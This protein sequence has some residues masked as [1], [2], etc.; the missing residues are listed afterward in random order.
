MPRR[1][2]S[3]LNITPDTVITTDAGEDFAIVSGG[4]VFAGGYGRI[5]QA[6]RIGEGRK[7]YAVKFMLDRDPKSLPRKNRN[8]VMAAD[9]LRFENEISHLKL[10]NGAG[11]AE[12]QDNGDFTFPFPRYYG[13]GIKLHKAFYVME[14]LEPI[15]YREIDTDAERVDFVCDLCDAVRLLHARGLVHYD[16]KPSNIMRRPHAESP[17]QWEYVLSDFGSVHK[18]EKSVRVQGEVSV[19]MLPNGERFVVP[20]TPGYADPLEDLHT[21][22]GD[23]YAVGQVIRD[24]FASDVPPHWAPI[25]FRSISRNRD[26]RYSEIS[27]MREDVKKMVHNAAVYLANAFAD[28]TG[29]EGIA[30]SSEKRRVYVRHGARI[31]GD[32][33]RRSPFKTIGEA[34]VAAES[35]DIIDVGAGVY[36]ESIDLAG[37]RLS[38]IASAGPRKTKIVGEPKRSVV[39][40]SAGAG[41]TLIKGFSISGGVGTPVPSSHGQDFY[42]GGVRAEVSAL[43][44]DCILEDNGRGV[45]KK[46]SCTF[47]GAVFVS[48]A[49]LTIRNC[50][51][52]NNFAWACGGGLMAAGVGGTLVVDDSTVVDNGSTPLVGGVKGGIAL[53]DHAILLLTES[54]VTGNAGSQIG[55]FGAYAQGTRAQVEDCVVQGGAVAADIEK[56]IA[57]A[58][59][60]I[61]RTS[62]TS[63]WG[64]HL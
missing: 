3:V 63:K 37:K 44:E 59:N 21:I 25:I 2:R 30:W 7:V 5:Y 15:N 61:R 20:N 42:G 47:G 16:I 39:R 32:G 4:C 56:F 54:I 45:P 60:K 28:L 51:I 58:G 12:E 18:V 49:T 46:T 13:R 40:L 23:I 11:K 43:I 57:G 33:T 17:L 22:N 8:A 50:L 41:A 1:Q 26:Y 24:L 29:P 31:G 6:V 62:K 9:K 52:R 53:S 27:Q 38:I 35:D 64:A 14:W 36:R 34:V 48:G 10:M 55:G 19:S